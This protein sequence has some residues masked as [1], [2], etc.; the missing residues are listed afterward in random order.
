MAEQDVTVRGYVQTTL[1]TGVA[2]FVGYFI[3]KRRINRWRLRFFAWLL[4]RLG[5]K[6]N[7]VFGEHK[8]KLFHSMDK[9]KTTVGPLKAL[10][11]G[12]GGGVNF[13]FYPSGTK[14]TCLDPNP[15]FESYAENNAEDN[16]G[17]EMAG[18]LQSFAENMAEV[19][20]CSYDVVVSTLVLCSV[21][22]P[23]RVLK[24]VKRVLKHNG[25]FYFLD[26]VRA[27]KRS[28]LYFFQR[29]MSPFW[30]VIGDGCELT[31]DIG[32]TVK[33][34]GFKSL[35]M[36]HFTAKTKMLLISPCCMGIATK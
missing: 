8:K 2:L 15:Y 14:V 17:V 19:S 12:A 35:D 3:F 33:E 28:I 23:N 27:P 22:D 5:C 7:K 11:I 36:R 4:A 18:F 20:D 26:H 34:A 6:S 10:E 13:K 30:R 21:R 9:L 24:E 1:Y 29:L 32:T 25:K 16:R 31:R